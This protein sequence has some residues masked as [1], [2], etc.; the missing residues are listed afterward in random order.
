[1]ESP[2]LGSKRATRQGFWWRAACGGGAPP[3]SAAHAAA[4]DAAR[5]A[6]REYEWV[7][8][9]KFRF[10]HDP[11]EEGL[12]TTCVLALEDGGVVYNRL[13]SRMALQKRPR[14]AVTRPSRVTVRKRGLTE[15]EEQE[16]AAIR[17]RLAAPDEEG[18]DAEEAVGAG[19]RRSSASPS[20]SD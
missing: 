17:Q 11:E 2:Q 10:E 14:G 5:D 3:A 6:E 4:P 1:M 15:E 18:E 16:R 7:R 20:L 8:E 9:Y 19:S 13:G 12:V